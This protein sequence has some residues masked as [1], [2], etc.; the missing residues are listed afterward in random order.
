MKN[1]IL[2]EARKFL[3]S[4][5]RDRQCEHETIHLWRKDWKFVVY[6]SFRVDSYVMKIL[7]GEDHKLSRK[8]IEL[9]RIAALLHDVGRIKD[10]ENH[11]QTGRII[12]KEWLDKNDQISSQI[13]NIEKLLYMIETHSNKDSLENDFSTNVL[14]DA[15]ILDEIGVL[16]IFMASNHLDKSSSFFFDD[17]LERVEGFE[18]DFCDKK[19]IKLKTSTAKKILKKKKD[20]IILF[21]NQ[22][23]SELEGRKEMLRVLE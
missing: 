2:L 12:V 19:M 14:K 21:S 7:K 1:D 13:H 10:R 22:L 15:D 23:S 6:H 4:Y 9:I 3:V 16:S 18:M 20:F 5:L 11:A 8:E 17:L